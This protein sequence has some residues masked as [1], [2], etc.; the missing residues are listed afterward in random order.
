MCLSVRSTTQD[1][2]LRFDLTRFNNR[3]FLANDFL[4]LDIFLPTSG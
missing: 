3:I 2:T 1:G 4:L